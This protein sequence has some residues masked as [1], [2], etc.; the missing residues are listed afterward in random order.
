MILLVQVLERG[1]NYVVITVKGTEL[2]ETTVCHAEE[3][4]RINDETEA[5]YEKNERSAN[6]TFSLSPLKQLTFGVYDDIKVSLNGVIE[7]PAF[8][9]LVK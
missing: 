6:F 9:D 2:Q 1:T 8:S 4:G 5:L 7:N 3:N